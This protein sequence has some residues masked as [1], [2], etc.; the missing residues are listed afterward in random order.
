MWPHGSACDRRIS[1]AGS[2]PL[3]GGV[4]V[5]GGQLNVHERCLAGPTG[6]PNRTWTSRAERS[7]SRPTSS[8][9]ERELQE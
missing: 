5:D 3:P 6:R 8:R 4:D 9:R 1:R 2:E 7:A